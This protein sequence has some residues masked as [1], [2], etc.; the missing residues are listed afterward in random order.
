V[1]NK[2]S[3]NSTDQRTTPRVST[4]SEAATSGNTKAEFS[5]NVNVLQNYHNREIDL[6]EGAI[7]LESRKVRLGVCAVK[8]QNPHTGFSTSVYAFHDSGSELTLLRKSAA[9]E[10]GLVGDPISQSCR[11]MNSTVKTDMEVTTLHIRGLLEDKAYELEDVRITDNVPKLT[12]SLPHHME[13]RLFDKFSDLPYPTLGRKQCDIL[14]GSD[15]INLLA[16]LEKEGS[17][18]TH[19]KIN[20]MHTR[21]G[22]VMRGPT[23]RQK[24]DDWCCEKHMKICAPTVNIC[25]NVQETKIKMN[26]RSIN[27][28][29]NHK[30]PKKKSQPL[31]D[32]IKRHSTHSAL[33]R[34]IAV[35]SMF[36]QFIQ[37]CSAT[38]NFPGTTSWQEKK[39][40]VRNQMIQIR[41]EPM[42]V[43]V[44]DLENAEL[45][46]ARYVQRR[47]YGSAIRHMSMDA[48]SYAQISDTTKNKLMKKELHSLGDLCPFFDSHGVLRVKGRLS[49]AD[50]SYDRRHQIILPKRHH[51][52]KLVTEKYHEDVGHAGP[53]I[54]L[55]ATRKKYWIT[56]GI[57]TVKHYIRACVI[58]IKK[59]SKAVPQFMGDHPASRIAT[60]QPAFSHTGIDYFGPFKTTTGIRNRTT[61]S[62]G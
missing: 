39:F 37:A 54:T 14:I 27:L 7:P 44:A 8:I 61:K 4:Y 36:K 57:N 29:S 5:N 49:N 6:P 51:Y 35:L 38:H 2:K 48:E 60:W 59:H 40:M 42:K 47:A 15:N 21:L 41:N 53:D 17:Q 11:G 19:D 9:R 55:G 34:Q 13:F 23:P 30:I 43:S 28:L 1:D 12:R 16:A 18:R 3:S 50:F 32:L 56:A 10:I 45:D 58:C 20:M 33:V 52:T 24:S 31:T 46:I 25:E 22:W 26:K 62:W